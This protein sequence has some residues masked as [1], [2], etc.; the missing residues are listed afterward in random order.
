MMQQVTK[1]VEALRDQLLFQ[2]QMAEANASKV[3]QLEKE[4]ELMVQAYE[5]KVTELDSALRQ[6]RQELRGAGSERS[7]SHTRA[8]TAEGRVDELEEQVRRLQVGTCLGMA[9]SCHIT[10]NKRVCETAERCHMPNQ[11]VV[12]VMGRGRSEQQYVQP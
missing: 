3:R 10:Y 7:H 5:Q 2:N 6:A 4:K 8:V 9:A 11:H 12:K 1:E